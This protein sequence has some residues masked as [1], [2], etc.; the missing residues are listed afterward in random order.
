MNSN[1]PTI[2]DR[3]RLLALGSS[4]LAAAWFP[5]AALA[6]TGEP[7][8]VGVCGPLTG[9]YAQY[10]AQWK[11]GFDLALEEINAGGGINGRPLKYV[12][13]DSQSDPRQT[14]AIARKFVAD[15]KI[16]VEL[17]DFSSA[18]SMAASPIY[19]AAGMV[20]FGFT[21]SHPKF[22]D[23]G[24]FIWSNAVNQ[25][26]EMPLLA[27]FV[28]DLGLKRVAVLYINSDWGR[29]A[30]DIL[31]EAI[32]QRGLEAAGAEGYLADEKDFRSAIVRIRDSNPDGIALVSYYPDGAQ[33]ARQIKNAGL[34]QTLVAGGS[35]YSPKFIELG[36]EAVNGVLTTVPFFPD[37]PR[38][39]VQKFVKAFIAK[40]AEQ[41]DAYNGRAYDSMILLA[42]VMRQT[43]ITRQSI[44][45]GLAKISGVP[46]VVF[47]Q[48]KFD[49][50]TRRVANPIV[51][52]IKVEDG[53]WVAWKKP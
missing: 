53:K 38:P 46:S 29:T 5:A 37:D 1:E 23:G 30:K 28:R 42:A 41:P 45:E 17:G 44:K 47:G 33:I 4:A 27:D 9:Q 40:F 48:V 31:V 14:V 13:E 18:A 49:P 26:D 2:P 34:K 52:R 3:R 22:T 16:L 24:D 51:S 6:Q 39:E 19:Q 11:K 15:E 25:A 43:G 35:I 10:G 21:N 12:F 32:K 20:Q 8:V 36:G 7:V 50:Q